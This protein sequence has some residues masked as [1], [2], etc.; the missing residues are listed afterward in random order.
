MVR[1]IKCIGI[2]LILITIAACNNGRYSSSD[3][4]SLSK[5][6]MNLQLQ[7]TDTMGANYHFNGTEGT[8][9][10]IITT[11]NPSLNSYPAY[12]SLELATIQGTLKTYNKLNVKPFHG[13][14]VPGGESQSA[15]ILPNVIL[16]LGPHLCSI[17]ALNVEM[18]SGHSVFIEFQ[19]KIAMNQII[20]VG[21][22]PHQ[23]NINPCDGVSPLSETNND[24]DS[25]QGNTATVSFSRDI[26][27][28][29]AN[30]CTRCHTE[31]YSYQGVRST[32]WAKDVSKSGLYRALNGEMSRYAPA[33]LSEVVKTW[34]NEGALNN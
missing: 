1:F 34:I 21:A 19:N 18:L 16:P 27:P 9:D 11:T 6:G 7:S 14:F 20:A 30:H 17:L 13:I 26:A 24:D 3:A 25:S 31:F 32:V 12:T 4:S 2:G 15:Q 10:I 5:L 33:G 8:Y 22:I 29:L 23:S 28:V